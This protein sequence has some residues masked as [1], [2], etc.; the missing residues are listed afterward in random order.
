MRCTLLPSAGRAALPHL[1]ILPRGETTEQWQEQPRRHKLRPSH[2]LRCFS[3]TRR[4]I[5]CYS[6]PRGEKGGCWR[7]WQK[8]TLKFSLSV[9]CSSPSVTFCLH[10]PTASTATSLAREKA[11]GTQDLP[12]CMVSKHKPPA[13]PLAIQGNKAGT[14]CTGAQ[15]RRDPPELGGVLSAGSARQHTQRLRVTGYAET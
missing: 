9:H 6:R 14:F 13:L 10:H 1:Q 4:G 12:P 15:S 5:S 3:S 11:L 2:S 7:L 8:A